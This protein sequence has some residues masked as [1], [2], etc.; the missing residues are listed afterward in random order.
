MV[1]VKG[2]GE[3]GTTASHTTPLVSNS[4]TG[5]WRVSFW[6][7]KNA[8][9]TRWTAPAGEAARAT[10]VGSGSGRI[11]TL[12]TDPAAAQTA[13]TPPDTGGLTAT[14]DAAANAATMWTLLLKP[15]T[16]APPVNQ[17]PVARFTSVCADLTCDFDASTSSDA[18]DTISSYAWD[19][20]DHS[21]GDQVTEHHPY[22]AAG[23]YG[24]TLTVTDDSGAT[25]SVTHSVTAGTAPPPSAISYVGQ[26][27]SNVNSTSVTVKVPATVQTGDGLL[28]F[29]SQGK[30]Q[31]FTGP[32]A[33]WTQIGSV[34]D[35][36]VATTVWRQ[37][38]SAGDA[39]SSVQLTT[40]RPARSR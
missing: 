21:S 22:T 12:L 24:V 20:D 23:T 28:L 31:A 36:E 3:P 17:P 26:A 11:D 7:D 16:D 38:A 15:A 9:T 25:N 6:T 37:V 29:A 2:V 40:G 4:T 33:G 27:S 10:T 8:A 19:F 18:E 5:A 32:G 34:T 13:D 14:T 39:G 1:A 35:G 30:S